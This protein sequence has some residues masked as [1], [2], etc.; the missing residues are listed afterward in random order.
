VLRAATFDAA[1]QAGQGND[2]GRIA[3]GRLADFVVSRSDPLHDISSIRSLEFVVR[4]G[5]LYRTSELRSA[6]HVSD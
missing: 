3:V 6:V 4:G 5:V 2:L 1:R